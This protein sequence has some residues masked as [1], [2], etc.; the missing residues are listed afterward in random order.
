[1]AVNRSIRMWVVAG[2]VAAL[3]NCTEQRPTPTFCDFSSPLGPSCEVSNWTM[4]GLGV[5]SSCANCLLTAIPEFTDYSSDWS[6]CCGFWSCFCRCPYLDEGCY[7]GCESDIDA[8]CAMTWAQIW[9]EARHECPVVSEGVELGC[10]AECADQELAVSLSDLADVEARLGGAQMF[11]PVPCQNGD[12]GISLVLDSGHDSA[13]RDSRA[14][15]TEHDSSFSDSP[16]DSAR[17]DALS[18]STATEAEDSASTDANR[19]ATL[20]DGASNSD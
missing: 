9:Y 4:V 12:G 14:D 3:S 10:E 20:V 13:S 16:A 2:V 17:K 8:D 19:D 1:L 5:S 6:Y 7:Q 18:D 11:I 15:T